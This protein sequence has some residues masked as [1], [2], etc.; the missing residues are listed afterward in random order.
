MTPSI[1]LVDDDRA[2]LYAL[3][4]MLADLPAQLVLVNSGEEAL[5]QVLRR[6]FAAIL[7]DVRLPHMDGFEV[8]A[9]I[10]SLER[11]RRTPIVFMSAYEDRRR[12]PRPSA[13]YERYFRKPLVPEVVREALLEVLPPAR[14]DRGVPARPA[15]RDP[16]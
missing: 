5:R 16:L 9:A 3:S 2:A 11:L 7:L 14:A 4:E 1:L 10:R 12:Q 6:E 13:L 8:A 15:L